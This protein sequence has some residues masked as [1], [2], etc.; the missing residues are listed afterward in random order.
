MARKRR[1]KLRRRAERQAETR[2]R[3]V[4]ATVA[5]HTTVGPKHTTVA[6]IAE[7][8]GVERPTFY[9]HFPTPS[10]LFGACSAYGWATNPPPDPEP[11]LAINDPEARLREAL[12]QLYAYYERN[13]HGMW[14][15]LRDLEDMRELRPFA[16]HRIAHRKRVCKVLVN[17]W[18]NDGGQQKL[19]SAAI[20]HA[21]DFF[22]WRTLRRQGLSND[23]A[24]DLMVNLVRSC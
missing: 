7:R 17:A 20:G 2:Q 3:I 23:E 4:E 1:Y 22:T 10:A 9:R 12:S 5:L 24:A 18:P 13:E 16:S 6:A 14:V 21:V 8:A 11:W 15:I 19:L